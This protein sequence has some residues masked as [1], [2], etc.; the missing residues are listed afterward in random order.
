MH[1]IFVEFQWFDA[2]GGRLYLCIKCNLGCI[3]GYLVYSF[4]SYLLRARHATCT[5][6]HLSNLASFLQ[7]THE[8]MAKFPLNI[9]T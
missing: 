3:V 6:C 1:N 8:S 2:H 9:K 4:C 7:M 5:H